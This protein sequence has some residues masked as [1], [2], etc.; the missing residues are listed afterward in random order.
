MDDEVRDSGHWR[1][2]AQKSATSAARS[3]DQR[4]GRSCTQESAAP[5]SRWVSLQ[6][7]LS[8][9]SGASVGKAH[10]QVVQSATTRR[11]IERHQKGGTKGR[12]A[13]NSS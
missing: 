7:W 3:M 13:K 9:E 11:R 2:T 1:R 12:T 5:L 8:T 4:H 6:K 10:W